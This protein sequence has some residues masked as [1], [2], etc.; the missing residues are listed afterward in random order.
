VPQ[1]SGVSVSFLMTAMMM[2]MWMLLLIVTEHASKTPF[3][4]LTLTGLIIP[5]SNHVITQF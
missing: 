2:M 5:K 3:F 4:K 1:T